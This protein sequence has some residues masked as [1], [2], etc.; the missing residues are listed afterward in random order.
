MVIEF[1]GVSITLF[2]YRAKRKATEFI[3][4][5]AIVKRRLVL[6]SC[7]DL[8]LLEYSDIEVVLRPSGFRAWFSRPLF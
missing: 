5:S 7:I 6:L 2:I 1:K 3:G 4:L 8:S